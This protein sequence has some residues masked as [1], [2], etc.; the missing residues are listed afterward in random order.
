VR[1][2]SAAWFVSLRFCACKREVVDGSETTISTAANVLRSS[3]NGATV[4]GGAHIGQSRECEA[5]SR[6]HGIIIVMYYNDH[7]PPD[8]H[9]KCGSYEITVRIRDG[10]VEGRF[11]QRAP[12]L[13]SAWYSSRRVSLLEDWNLA[14]QHQP[15]RPSEPLE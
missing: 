5:C 15:L 3:A 13:V 4:R 2:G 11:P 10:L 6:N 1:S 8:L 7:A 12:M 9:A 14:R